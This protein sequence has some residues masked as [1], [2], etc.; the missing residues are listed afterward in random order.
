MPE[1][2]TACGKKPEN[3]AINSTPVVGSAIENPSSAIAAPKDYKTI[4]PVKQNEGKKVRPSFGKKKK[5]F[6]P[7]TT[8]PASPNTATSETSVKTAPILSTPTKPKPTLQESTNETNADTVQT[9][10][11]TDS[12]PKKTK[13]KKKEK[14]VDFSKQ[15]S[16]GKDVKESKENTQTETGSKSTSAKESTPAKPKKKTAAQEERERKHLEREKAK[17]EKEEAKREKERLKVEKKLEQEKKKAEKGQ[18]KMEKE[19][20]K[21]EK[22]QT[23]LA[24]T[25][26]KLNPPK[27]SQT[28]K[29]EQ[30]PADNCP[31]D[32]THDK[33][34]TNAQENSAPMSSTPKEAPP[35]ETGKLDIQELSP[36]HSTQENS[37]LM[38]SILA[39]APFNETSN[40]DNQKLPTNSTKQSLIVCESTTPAKSSSREI[41]KN[42]MRDNCAD[43]EHNAAKEERLAKPKKRKQQ[44]DTQ[45]SASKKFKPNFGVSKPIPS[46]GKQ[47]KPAIT[48]LKKSKPK[49][50]KPSKQAKYSSRSK[51]VNYSGPVWVQCDSC[52]KWRTLSSIADPS[53]VPDH[54]TCSMNKDTEHT[55]CEAPEEVWSDLGDSQEFVESPF[56]PGSLVWAKM[57]G[58][59]W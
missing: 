52:D 21:M 33:N 30:A 58:Y 43:A 15:I 7:P 34:D 45:V 19:L 46:Q 2:T 42:D 49:P 10:A 35:N 39:E 54:W 29:S 24:K 41:N 4:V 22:L 59:P 6:S 20:K 57:D 44:S 8:K 16:S 48:L 11:K 17:S 53:L 3:V 5:S 56:I 26:T 1:N 55:T 36:I 9:E 14:K 25:K 32:E 40:L 51:A 13:A 18:K 27:S 12:I 37:T 28:D 50:S 31:I 38:N 23:S 47:D